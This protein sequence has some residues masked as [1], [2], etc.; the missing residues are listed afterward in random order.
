MQSS[1]PALARLAPS[2]S[3]NAY[4][5]PGWYQPGAG[6]TATYPGVIT[7]GETMTVDG[8]IGRTL[9]LI[10]LLTVSAAAAWIWLP[11]Q[12]S[13]VVLLVSAIGAL[14]LGLVISIGRLTNPLLIGAYAVVEGV[15]L[16]LVSEA[17][18]GQYGGIVAQAVT[19]TIGI[20]FVMLILYRFRVIRATPRFTKGLLGALIA[21]VVLMLGNWLLSIFGVHTGLREGGTIGIIF[22]LAMIVLGALTFILD[23]DL[24]EQGVRDGLPQRY[25]WYAAF[26]IILGVIWV[27]LEVLRLLSYLRGRD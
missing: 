4:G 25:G 2:S 3:S 11:E 24:V 19:A 15:V 23:F 26:G 27:Y 5:E 17:F 16:G 18:E 9:A 7:R 22:S 1:N 10:L 8:V 20:F 21:A 14:I 6:G 12:L 13:G